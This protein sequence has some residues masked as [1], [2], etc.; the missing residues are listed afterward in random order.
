M[1]RFLRRYDRSYHRGDEGVYCLTERDGSKILDSNRVTCIQTF[2]SIDGD[3]SGGTATDTD[4]GRGCTTTSS[5]RFG[6][7]Y[8]EA[9]TVGLTRQRLRGCVGRGVSAGRSFVRVQE[10]D[11]DVRTPDE[12]SPPVALMSGEGRAWSRAWTLTD[13]DSVRIR[14]SDIF[15]WI[16]GF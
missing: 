6:P 7:D 15:R 11:V 10:S 5:R 12:V 1:R 9:A 16:M 14:G 2:R 3:L 13:I 8:V 4:T